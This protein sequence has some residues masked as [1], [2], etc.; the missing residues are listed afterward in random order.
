MDGLNLF[1]KSEKNSP[2]LLPDGHDSRFEL[3]FLEY[4]TSKD[5]EWKVCIGV[6]YGPS[7]WQVG[8]SIEQIGCFKM[9]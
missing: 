6:P 4:I 9:A 7:Y 3:S 1:D 8:D 5:P 2:Y